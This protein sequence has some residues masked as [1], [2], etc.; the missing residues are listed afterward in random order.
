MKLS[1]MSLVGRV[2]AAV[3]LMCY[4]TPSGRAAARL[5]G[6]RTRHPGPDD[7]NT[8]LDNPSVVRLQGRSRAYSP[9]L[10]RMQ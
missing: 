2:G 7:R 9:W 5:R 8:T 6:N 3:Y 4:G 10:S 1:I